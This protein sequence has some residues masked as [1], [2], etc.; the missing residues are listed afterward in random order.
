MVIKIF[1]DWA[2]YWSVPALLFTNRGFVDI[3]IL[4]ELFSTPT[5]LG[6]KFGELSR[7][8]QDLFS[9]WAPY[10]T[11][12]FSNRYIDPLDLD[13]LKEFQHGIEKQYEPK[14]LIE[15]I[16][17]NM[18]VLEKVAA[19]I[20]RL[21]SAQVHDTPMDMKVN[22]YTISLDKNP[23]EMGSEEGLLGVDMDIRKDVA[24]MWFYKQKQLV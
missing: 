17:Q 20:F 19:E 8:M 3:K 5:G 22:P 12:I 23:S 11:E 10:D 9:A 1:W 13:Y 14:D 24:R 15:K 16:R 18:T 6:R 4:K 7:R 21:V 2:T